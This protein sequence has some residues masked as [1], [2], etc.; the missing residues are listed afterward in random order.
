MKTAI[1]S[2]LCLA[3]AVRASGQAQEVQKV[4]VVITSDYYAQPKVL[5]HMP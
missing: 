3:F 5:V 1:M 4:P 2:V